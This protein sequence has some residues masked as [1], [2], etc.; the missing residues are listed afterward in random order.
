MGKFELAWQTPSS[1]VD[2][3]KWKVELLLVGW[4]ET[5][6][7]SSLSKSLDDRLTRLHLWRNH[8][9]VNSHHLWPLV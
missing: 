6:G 4:L 8:I 9:M 3:E 5:K 7:V 2:Q 1:W